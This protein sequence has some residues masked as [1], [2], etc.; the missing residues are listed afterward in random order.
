MDDLM[1]LSSGE[2]VNGRFEMSGGFDTKG[3]D[4]LVFFDAEEFTLTITDE[5]TQAY[6]KI[7]LSRYINE[8]G[9]QFHHPGNGQVRS[10]FDQKLVDVTFAVIFFFTVLSSHCFC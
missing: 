10:Q 8:R 1:M 4:A 5:V 9:L 2:V 3:K 6:I 7:D